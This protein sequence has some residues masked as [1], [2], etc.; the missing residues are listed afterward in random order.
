MTQFTF[1]DDHDGYGQPRRQ[2]TL[3]VPGGRDPKTIALPG[4]PYL[5]TVTTTRYAVRDEA[6]RY[7]VDRVAVS[8]SSEIVNDG[9]QAVA[10]LYRAVQDGMATI[11]VYG[12]TCTYYDGAAFVGLPL[13]A[14]G[15]FAAPVRTERLVLTDELLRRAHVDPS[16]PGG[17][18]IPP[19]LQPQG[20]AGRRPEY[21]SEFLQVLP[22]LAGYTVAD[23]SDGRV[24][25]YYAQVSRVALDVH[26]LELPHRGLPVTTRDALG[27]DTTV[28]YGAPFHVLPETVVDPVGL[29]VKAD[30]DYRV[31]KPR[32]VTDENGN[33]R[34]WTFTPLNLVASTAIMGTVGETAGDTE[35]EPGVRF[36]YDLL[37]FVE[38]GLPASVRSTAREHHA[39]D[40]DVPLPRRDATIT[41]VEYSDGF[42]RLVQTRKQAE[43]VRFGDPSFGGGVL[44]ADQ[45]IAAG[46]T[47]GQTRA[48]GDPLNVVV[49]GLQVYDNKGRVVERYEPFFATGLDYQAAGGAVL[50]QK[51]GDDYDPRGQVFRT[52]YP[53]GSEERVIRGVPA[54]LTRPDQ[55]AP[56]PFEIFSYDP[57]DLAPVSLAP[58]G[59]PLAASAPPAHHFTP[60]STVLDALGRAVE[61]VRRNS[62]GPDSDIRIK[63]T[64]EHPVGIG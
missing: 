47:I 10:D 44:S 6:H 40:T 51:V 43:D 13:G 23:G 38:R 60:S 45:A 26:H 8:T 1:T 2:V 14:L 17:V 37:A 39:T 46:D 42:G 30:N 15:D 53:D 5:G 9:S 50:G 31:L 32:Q 3:A 34:P 24:R 54:D 7:V 57:N 48:E 49:S 52:V 25:G 36:E 19:Y 22:E 62:A 21:P 56:T 58:D 11:A 59:S 4:E 55:F 41:T 12:Q 63:S 29:T 20:A 16:A 28:G 18:A 27:H 35:A 64:Y 61:T 33:R